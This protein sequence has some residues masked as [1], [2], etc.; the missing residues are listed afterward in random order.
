ML[1][2]AEPAKPRSLSSVSLLRG[3][4][5]RAAARVMMLCYLPVREVCWR[6]NL[7]FCCRG[8]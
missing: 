1:N 7:S 4:H 3:G 8:S 6:L 5:L 2:E